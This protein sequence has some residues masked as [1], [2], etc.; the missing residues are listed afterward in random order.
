VNAGNVVRCVTCRNILGQVNAGAIIS[1]HKGRQFTAQLPASIRC[2]ECGSVWRSP[3]EPPV[4]S[5]Q[6]IVG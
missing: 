2:E 4:T 1:R 3:P 6:S 5:L